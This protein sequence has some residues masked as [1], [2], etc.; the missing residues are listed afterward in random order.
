MDL[1]EEVWLPIFVGRVFAGEDAEDREEEEPEESCSAILG[2]ILSTLCQRI[3]FSSLLST[4]DPQ[5]HKHPQAYG[6]LSCQSLTSQLQFHLVSIYNRL[7]MGKNVTQTELEA[8]SRNWLYKLIR[9]SKHW[10]TGLAF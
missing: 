9:R 1:L 8:V 10:D 6:K 4:L 2:F 5:F 3:F 7:E